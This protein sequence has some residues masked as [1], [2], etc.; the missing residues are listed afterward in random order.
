MFPWW[1]QAFD[2]GA[3]ASSPVRT[4]SQAGLGDL[5]S[6][7]VTVRVQ[8]PHV[9]GRM[10]TNTNSA[11]YPFR[12]GMTHVVHPRGSSNRG[13]LAGLRLCM[14][15]HVGNSGGSRTWQGPLGRR[16][17]WES[18]HPGQRVSARRSACEDHRRGRHWQ[19]SI[20]GCRS[21]YGT[22]RTSR[23]GP[24]GD[25]P[26]DL[27]GSGLAHSVPMHRFVHTS[28][29]IPRT[30]AMVRTTPFC[31]FDGATY[32]AL[33]RKAGCALAMANEY[34]PASI[35][36]RSLRKSPKTIVCARVIPSDC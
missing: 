33:A 14:V 23:R 35:I 8:R 34:S 4:E 13:R 2:S 28:Q 31:V 25:P 32:R 1:E 29:E 36:S 3:V 30:D 24:T 21:R 6:L 26:G 12:G 20:A 5:A 9:S 16:P 27:T 11:F 19:P 10:R 17:D 22:T 15:M 7:H 18:A